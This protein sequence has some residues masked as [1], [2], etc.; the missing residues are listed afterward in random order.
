MTTQFRRLPPSLL[1]IAA[2]TL[3]GCSVL[4]P[5]PPPPTTAT[6]ELRDLGGKTVGNATLTQMSDGVRLVLDARGLPP[7]ER[8]V[9]FHEKGQCEP[10]FATAGG[11]F[12]PDRK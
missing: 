11:H 9:H 7:G 5:S 6:A 1:A 3:T 8:A 10:P 4:L 2:P 12:N